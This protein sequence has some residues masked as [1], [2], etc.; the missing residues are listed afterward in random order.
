M[1]TEACRWRLK[2]LQL[3]KILS[4]L[5][6]GYFMCERRGNGAFG[7]WKWGIMKVWA[8][9]VVRIGDEAMVDADRHGDVGGGMAG[10][11]ARG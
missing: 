1:Q 10:S 4:L 2:A 8:A 5:E 7:S 9:Y 3:Q 6:A 11:G